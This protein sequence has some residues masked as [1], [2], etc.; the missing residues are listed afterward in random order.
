[1]DIFKQIYIQDDISFIDR[2]IARNIDFILNDN[3]IYQLIAANYGNFAKEYSEE[4]KKFQRQNERY[5][6]L[7]HRI[8]A[9][10][11]ET[12]DKKYF[13]LLN[14]RKASI[15]ECYEH[16]RKLYLDSTKVYNEI[17]QKLND[18]EGVLDAIRKTKSFMIGVY[19]KMINVGYNFTI[20][21]V[22]LKEIIHFLFTDRRNQDDRI[23]NHL[24]SILSSHLLKPIPLIRDR[25]ELDL[26]HIKLNPNL[27]QETV[28]HYQSLFYEFLNEE[29]RDFDYF[30]ML[31]LRHTELSEINNYLNH[32][33]Q[34]FEDDFKAFL[35]NALENYKQHLQ[36][37]QIVKV[38]K[39]LE[40]NKDKNF[41][42]ISIKRAGTGKRTKYDKF[43]TLSA[44]QTSVLF[45]YLK[46]SKVVLNDTSLQKDTEI[47]K[48]VSTMTGY[49]ENSI[50]QGLIQAKKIDEIN[51]DDLR[52]TQ[53]KLKEIIR[54]ID[55]DLE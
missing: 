49:S 43:T 32:H 25:R 15:L 9:K 41:K 22:F 34:Q 19:E 10:L 13:S 27:I 53:K 54:L 17:H 46:K 47:A 1:M 33:A 23:I 4:I 40:D 55:K 2:D 37:K 35:H 45:H 28:S 48:A 26:T 6:S 3:V 7:L 20:G 12:T 36:D 16:N 14:N 38:E 31:K 39:W 50:R 30:F 42:T 21:S 52:V 11:K 5:V 51:K 24:E 18:N 29:N 8:D 44:D